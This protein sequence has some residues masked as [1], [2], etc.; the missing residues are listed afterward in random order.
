MVLVELL[1]VYIQ[2]VSGFE[3]V[4]RYEWAPRDMASSER[5]VTCVD[6]LTVRTHSILSQSH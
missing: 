5:A 2:E 4:P 1:E 3:L 6:L